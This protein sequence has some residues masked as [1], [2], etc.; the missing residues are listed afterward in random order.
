MSRVC[1]KPDH[2]RAAIVIVCGLD[3]NSW[4]RSLVRQGTERNYDYPR[5][6][7]TGFVTF[8]EYRNL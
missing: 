4:I 7:N 6:D 8:A 1:I 3:S 5:L 2:G